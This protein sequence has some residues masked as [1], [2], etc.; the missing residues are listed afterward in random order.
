MDKEGKLPCILFNCLLRFNSPK[1]MN[2]A[3]DGPVR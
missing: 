1:D 2:K 3:R